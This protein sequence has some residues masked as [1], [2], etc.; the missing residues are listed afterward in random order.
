[1]S[2]HEGDDPVV[3][4]RYADVADLAAQIAK[5]IYPYPQDQHRQETL[6]YVLTLFAAEIRRSAI[7]P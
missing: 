4:V 7:E 3:P 2:D 6:T 1:M 5:V